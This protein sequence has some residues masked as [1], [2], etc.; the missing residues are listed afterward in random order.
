MK[1]L[2]TILSILSCIHLYAQTIVHV[3][4][5][6]A[7]GQQ[8]GAD[9]TNAMSDLQQAL[10][11]AQA[12]DAIWVAAG[13]YLP[14]LG[15]DRSISFNLK[16]GVRLYG[17]FSG[18][19]TVLN[20]R[21]YALN[22]TILS[23]DIGVAGDNSDNSYHVLYGTDIDSSCILDGFTITKGEA[24]GGSFPYTNGWGGG[25]MLEPGFDIPNTCPVIQSC[26]FENNFA[27]VGG[28]IY[29]GWEPGGYLVNPILRNC[30]FM[31]NRAANF[32]GAFYK[33]SAA[34]ENQAFVMEDCRF[35]GNTALNGEGGGCYLI[36]RGDTTIFRRCVF[37]RDSSRI[38]LAGGLYFARS[39]N[40]SPHASYLLLDSCIFKQN[41]GT[42]AG[43]LMIWDLVDTEGSGMIKFNMINCIFDRNKAANGD[44]AAYYVKGSP[45][46]TKVDM[47]LKTCLFTGNLS[48]T[49]ATTLIKSLGLEG[50]CNLIIKDCKY[51]N[52]KNNSNPATPTFAIYYTGGKKF[53]TTIEN[54]LFANNAAG[55]TALI[56]EAAKGLLFIKNCTF[57]KNG[58]YA[59]NKSWFNT[60]DG[61]NTFHDCYISNC[62]FQENSTIDKMFSNN[63]FMNINMYDYHI[64]YSMVSLPDPFVPG[65]PE[66][67]GDSVLFNMD[68]MFTDAL[69]GDYHLKPCSPA[70]NSGDNAALDTTG[71]L[72]DLDGL[73][74]ILHDIVDMGAY[75]T[76]DTCAVSAVDETLIVN[77]FLI[78]PNPSTGLLRFELPVENATEKILLTIFDA[79]GRVVYR[80]KGLWRS[81]YSFQLDHLSQGV[82]SVQVTTPS[83]RWIGEWVKI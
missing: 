41:C 35:E 55:V 80:E 46:G 51:L 62:I 81:I 70:V 38:S 30:V 57:T 7:G 25:M 31:F 11:I 69:N 20:Q 68:P 32:A 26:R 33:K 59:I 39:S 37:E 63:D 40:N 71:L 27:S 53:N 13:T 67:F 44:G 18:T 48:D 83:D 64:D 23:G 82:Y 2:L 54:C 17:G 28:A 73:P 61:I 75:E 5:N 58:K 50:E 77:R 21:N 49:Y 65:G 4:V 9:W 74:R 10:A 19:E 22:E 42:E 34:A 56:A 16:Q 3:N 47:S 45:Y 24:S 79:K 15:T 78:S 76:P 60:Y 29:C 43:G 1:S 6:T 12:G 14:T 8:T 36:A 66:A 52:N 72:T